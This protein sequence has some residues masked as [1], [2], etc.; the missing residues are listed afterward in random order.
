MTLKASD[1]FRVTVAVAEKN[2]TVSVDHTDHDIET[3][4]SYTQAITVTNNTNEPRSIMWG[5][6]YEGPNQVLTPGYP[7]QAMLPLSPSTS[8]DTFGPY[9]T[10]TFTRTL[11]TKDKVEAGTKVKIHWWVVD[12]TN[13][14]L[15]GSHTHYA[16]QVV[17]EVAP[18]IVV[19]HSDH[20]INT[21]TSYSQ[22]ITV[23]NNTNQPRNLTID[24]DYG[25]VG[26]GLAADVMQR[27]TTIANVPFAAYETRSFTVA[28]RTKNNLLA[29]TTADIRWQAYDVS[30]PTLS[31]THTHKVT[32]ALEL[33]APTIVGP[34][35]QHGAPAEKKDLVW[36]I[37][38]NSKSA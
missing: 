4:T 17:E 36:T 27:D 3:S 20:E 32:V 25:S 35:A 23:T 15:K 10:R 9:E 24:L 22:K 14:E 16:T 33:A 8:I 7:H 31:K 1:T 37:T 11:V 30:K 38:N 19:D 12:Q 6:D 2:P 29:G 34:G 13:T 28:L 21:S 18:T 26:G 5:L